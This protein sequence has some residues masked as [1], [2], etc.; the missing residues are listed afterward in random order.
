MTRRR[1]KRNKVFKIDILLVFLII[2]ASSYFI[3]NVMLFVGV[4]DF[5]RY[6]IIGLVIVFNLF[7]I[8]KTFKRG[9][10][11][12]KLPFRIIKRIL[13]LLYIVFVIFVSYYVSNIYQVLSS[14]NQDISKSTSLV[15]LTSNEVNDIEDVKNSKIAIVDM[16]DDVQAYKLPQEIITEHKLEKS[17][18]IVFYNLYTEMIHDLEDK[19]VD[20]IFLPTNYIDIFGEDEEFDNLVENTKIIISKTRTLSKSESELLSTSKK[21]TEPF[22]ILLLGVDS[23]VDGLK[24]V[25]SFNGDSITL[26]TYNPKTL[27]ATMLSIPRDS[28]VPISCFAGKMENKITHAAG[29][30]TKCV[31][32]TISNFTGIKIDYYIKINFTGLVDLVDAV[33]GVDVDVPYALCEQ[34]SKRRWGRYTVFVDKGMQ[35]LNGE[36]AL[37]LS[38]NRHNYAGR[39]K[40]KYT[41]GNRS[42]F[43]RGQNQQ[44]IIKGLIDSIKHIKSIDQANNVLDSVSKNIDT[45]MSTR[46]ILSFYDVL[47]DIVLKT[48][49]NSEIVHVQ[50]LKLTGHDQRI[51]D[52]RANRV[53][54]NYVLNKYSIKDVANAMK[55]NLSISKRKMVKT[56]TYNN[57]ENYQASIIGTGPYNSTGVYALLPNFS[58]MTKSEA[59]QWAFRNSFTIIWDEVETETT[60]TGV[61]ISQSYP[62]NKRIDLITKKEITLKIAKNIKVDE[63]DE[64]E[65]EDEVDDENLDDN[66]IDEDDN[67]DED[68]NLP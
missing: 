35:H 22:T 32:D 20:Y 23:T 4:E 41:Q 19:K 12:L 64:E 7:L 61:I 36:Q 62:S 38:R 58:N 43:V 16:K 52:E 27:S 30:G 51:F 3:Y 42:D 29:Y 28:Y 56:F 13:L 60:E 10:K 40:A 68:S 14:L 17:N 5:I 6:I 47:K 1:K 48:R 57:G 8:F 11:R 59:E 21:L 66:E 54:Y 9:R 50:R 34:D 26:V 44:L 39:C 25:D 37:A 46:T 15:T 45:N 33:G 31:T 63:E 49:D 24:N 67:E 55:A 65:E 18:E 2:I 53:L